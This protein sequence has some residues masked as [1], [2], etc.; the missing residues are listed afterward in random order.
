MQI[1]MPRVDKLSI[2]SKCLE[3]QYHSGHGPKWVPGTRLSKWPDHTMG[4][5]VVV[6]AAAAAAAAA[7]VVVVVV[8]VVV[9]LVVHAGAKRP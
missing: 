7:A 9:V 3:E 2:R 8:V 4:L 1:M 5:V 6:V